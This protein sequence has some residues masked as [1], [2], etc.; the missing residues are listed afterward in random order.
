ME[1]CA[2]KKAPVTV[3]CRWTAYLSSYQNVVLS[4]ISIQ[5]DK[6]FSLKIHLMNLTKLCL[7]ILEYYGQISISG[8]ILQRFKKHDLRLENKYAT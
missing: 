5:I 3:E 1:G 2:F 6:G 4:L 8:N 7:L